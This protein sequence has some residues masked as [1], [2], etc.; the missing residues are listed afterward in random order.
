M[1][2]VIT[3]LS[4]IT[5]IQI[6]LSCLL[7]YLY[8]LSGVFSGVFG[9]RDGFA[10]RKRGYSVDAVPRLVARQTDNCTTECS[11]ITQTESCN[12]DVACDCQIIT[13]QGTSGVS[14]C[15]NCVYPLNSTLADAVVLVGQDC[16]VNA[17][18]LV[19]FILP[20]TTSST[21]TS[22]STASK[23]SSTHVTTTN[24]KSSTSLLPSIPF[25]T[26]ATTS[27]KSKSS[28]TTA[29]TSSSVSAGNA[30]QTPQP[31]NSSSSSSSGLSGGAIAGIVVGIVGFFVI[32]AGLM[33]WLIRRH[34]GRS[35]PLPAAARED[36]APKVL[37]A[38]PP[39]AAGEDIIPSGRLRY[40]P[41]F[42][43]GDSDAAGG[44]LSRVY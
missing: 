44:R 13:T 32:L 29:S 12:G 5:D 10:G 24:S 26:S 3:L 1:A 9:A 19:T 43:G 31:K 35:P 16:G 38:P 25:I 42:Q 15:A 39:V 4:A 22:T 17:A 6:S 7:V 11:W 37:D 21:V 40:P 8:L 33:I 36:D 18:G 30:S 41:D 23:S 34:K 28:T 2:A 27:S 20:S 14:A